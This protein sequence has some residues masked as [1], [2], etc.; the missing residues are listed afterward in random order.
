MEL[1]ILASGGAYF[2]GNFYRAAIGRRGITNCKSEGDGATPAGTFRLCRVFFRADRVSPPQTDLDTA[3]ITPGDCWCDAPEDANY[4]SLVTLPYHS[5]CEPLYRKD[6]AYDILVTTSHNTNPTI[7]GAG[8]AIFLH[9]IKH[10]TY[11]PTEGCIAFSESGL[12]E[13]LE[14]W[15]PLSDYLVIGSNPVVQK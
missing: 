14:S 11:E 1:Y 4:N 15:N 6:P 5:S 13:I 8:S 12:R 7:P 10:P 9:V 2:G 3:Q